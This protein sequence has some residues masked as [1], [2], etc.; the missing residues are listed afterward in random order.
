M[1]VIRNSDGSNAGAD[2][3][4]LGRELLEHAGHSGGPL[5]KVIRAKCL[6]CCCDQ[7]SE[8]ARCTVSGCPLW[9][10]RMGKNPFARPRGRPFPK[11]SASSEFSPQ[12]ARVSNGAGRSNRGGSP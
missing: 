4:R 10:Y 11:A 1:P 8:V 3:R 7:P 9:P 6:D 5:L 12:T 2:P